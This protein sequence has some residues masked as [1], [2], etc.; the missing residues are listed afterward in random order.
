METLYKIVYVLLAIVSSMGLF[1]IGLTLAVIAL[2]LITLVIEGIKLA[3]D[4][5]FDD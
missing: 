1:C 3:I 2:F 4:V 5:V